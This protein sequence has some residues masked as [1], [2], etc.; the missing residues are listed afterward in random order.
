MSLMIFAFMM[1]NQTLI[2]MAKAV[3]NKYPRQIHMTP[4][5]IKALRF[6]ATS[7]MD[8]KLSVVKKNLLDLG[9]RKRG[10]GKSKNCA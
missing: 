4:S 5:L 7:K 8:L 2:L 3:V 10:L 1:M 9:T 6:D